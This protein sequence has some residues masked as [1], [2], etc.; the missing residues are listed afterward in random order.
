M[1]FYSTHRI[2]LQIVVVN[3]YGSHIFETKFDVHE[4]DTFLDEISKYM[5]RTRGSRESHRQVHLLS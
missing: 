3:K 2:L 5:P 1:H 4:F